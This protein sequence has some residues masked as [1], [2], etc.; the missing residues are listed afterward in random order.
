[1][2]SFFE[3]L[4]QSHLALGQSHVALRQ[5]IP[6]RTEH[7]TASPKQEGLLVKDRSS[8]AKHSGAADEVW[9]HGYHIS[10]T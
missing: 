9:Y 8:L 4:G 10:R 1:M 6:S 5:V 3:G 2:I 7:S